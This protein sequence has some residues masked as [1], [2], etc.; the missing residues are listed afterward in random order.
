MSLAAKKIRNNQI[1]PEKWL[2]LQVELCPLRPLHNKKE[3]DKAVKAASLLASQNILNKDQQDYLESLS[4]VIESYEQKHFAA[5]TNN[6]TPIEVVKYLLNENGMNASDLGKLFGDRP[7]GWRI[8][9]GQREL[10]KTHIRILCER[11]KI[12][13][14]VFF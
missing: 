13:P 5:D 3:H 14:A 6:V 9:K 7:L 8:L 11:F 4:L 10:S 2:G 12:S 1:I